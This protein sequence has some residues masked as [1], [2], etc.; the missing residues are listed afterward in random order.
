VEISVADTGPGFPEEMLQR[1]FDPF[2]STKP[3]GLGLGLAICQSIATAHGGGLVAAN[4]RDKGATLTLTLPA[5][6]A[7]ASLL[8][9][10]A[11]AEA[12]QDQSM[13]PWPAT[14][15]TAEL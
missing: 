4:N 5:Q 15:A 2:H 13:P 9:S 7:N 12:P 6:P 14:D 8:N 3:N 10:S 1:A 11:Q